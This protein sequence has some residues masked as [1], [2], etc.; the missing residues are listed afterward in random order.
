M[1]DKKPNCEEVDGDICDL[2]NRSMVNSLILKTAPI[3]DVVVI[4]TSF[5]GNL[6]SIHAD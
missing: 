1:R 4:Q 5:G 6:R 3:L 2:S